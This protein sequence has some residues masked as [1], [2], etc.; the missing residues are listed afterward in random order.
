VKYVTDILPKLYIG[1]MRSIQWAT[2]NVH[3]FN[4]LDKVKPS[5]YL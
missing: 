4:S 2:C 1:R 3:T 5:R